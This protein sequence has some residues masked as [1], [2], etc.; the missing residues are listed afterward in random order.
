[1]LPA[2]SSPGAPLSHHAQAI[3]YLEHVVRH[4]PEL[5]GQVPDETNAKGF[6]TDGLLVDSD[7]IH[8]ALSDEEEVGISAD[9]PDRVIRRS[10]TS[11]TAVLNAL[12]VLY[13]S[14]CITSVACS[15]SAVAKS[16]GGIPGEAEDALIRF[17]AAQEGSLLFDPHFALRICVERGLIRALVLL[18]GMMGMHE[19]AV[20]LSLRRD[21]I[22]LAK[23]NACKPP[24][25]RLRKRLWLRVVEK[26]AASGDVKRIISLIRESQ[27]LSVRD[28]L[29]YMSD[30]MTID[31]FHADICECLDS[32][33]GQI[34]T[35]R[36]EMDDHR[37]ALQAFK[38]DLKHA[39]E[40]SVTI[41]QDQVCEICG[42]PAM[43]ERFYVFA[44][45]HCF[46]EAC[47]RALVLPV[48]RA[49]DQDK[50]LMELEAA[51]IEHQAAAAGASVGT[52]AKM[53]LA[54]VEEE[55]DG[56]LADDCPLCG[57]LMIETIKRP[58]IDPHEKDEME[59][60]AFE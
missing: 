20:D 32:Y 19:E 28:V 10:W 37:R 25:E 21:D 24:D 60:W 15:A 11:G 1:V 49:A 14:D 3:R 17:L 8:C 33:E 4:H 23:H 22:A 55:L 54:E 38:E 6:G 51:R 39:E 35:L 2:V 52:L 41:S 45:A 56:I 44:C 43:R 31:A 29:P 9:R 36:Q 47:L 57:R 27:E 48:L 13:A 53:T 40:Q 12:T 34:L 42:A 30:S 58:F 59:S 5:T 50:R 16:S 26:Q 18:Y 46:H 7:P